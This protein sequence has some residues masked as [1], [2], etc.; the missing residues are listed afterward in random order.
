[1]KKKQTIDDQIWKAV[2]HAVRS[3]E[4]KKERRLE[5]EHAA[6]MSRNTIQTL[7]NRNTVQTGALHVSGAGRQTKK[8]II[9]EQL[10][11]A[12]ELLIRIDLDMH[13]T[14]KVDSSTCTDIHKYLTDNKLV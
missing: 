8:G 10:D 13:C 3:R 4:N 2:D 1:M 14:G 12:N 6:A 11:K 7:M 9:Q 5:V